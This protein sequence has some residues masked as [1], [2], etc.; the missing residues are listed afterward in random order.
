[1]KFGADCRSVEIV[2]QAPLASRRL[3]IL[4]V[5][6]QAQKGVLVR[7]TPSITRCYVTSK[8]QR[9]EDVFVVQTDGVNFQ[10][11]W[12]HGDD[13][14]VNE[15]RSNDIGAMLD[16]Y[17]V[18]AARASIV[19]EISGVFGVYGISVDYRHLYLLADYMTFHGDYRPL[20]RLGIDSNASPWQKMTFETSSKFLLDACV[21]GDPDELVSPSARIILGQT[22]KS[23]TGAFDLLQPLSLY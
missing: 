9:G 21:Y 6:E 20:N 12:N 17:G 22:V 4:S 16:T 13:V 8:K 15:L 7:A 19:N 2:V 23:G 1:M 10:E 14:D 18:E 11:I 3:L 5:V